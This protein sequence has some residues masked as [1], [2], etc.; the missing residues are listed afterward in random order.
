MEL[1]HDELIELVIHSLY[2]SPEEWTHDSHFHTHKSR[3]GIPF[4]LHNKKLNVELVR[5]R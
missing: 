3:I 1:T 5:V 2:V 4:T